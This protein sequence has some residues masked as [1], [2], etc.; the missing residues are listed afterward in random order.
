MATEEEEKKMTEAFEQELFQHIAESR[1]TR[2]EQQQ[3]PMRFPM[4]DRSLPLSAS[5]K[6]QLQQR[7]LRNSA[8]LRLVREMYCTAQR[9]KE[10]GMLATKALE[11]PSITV[12]SHSGSDLSLPISRLSTLQLLPRLSSEDS[13]PSSPATHSPTATA[14][15]GVT[16]AAARA[17]VPTISIAG[18]TRRKP[19][20]T[21]ARKP[22]QVHDVE[23]V[24]EE[25]E[26]E[27]EEE[28]ARNS[29][30]TDDELTFHLS[31]AWEPL[32][33]Q[34][35]MQSQLHAQLHSQMQPQ[36]LS[37]HYHRSQHPAM[38]GGR[39]TRNEE[40][41]TH[42]AASHATPPPP[43][44]AA[45]LAAEYVTWEPICRT[46]LDQLA[47]KVRGARNSWENIG[48]V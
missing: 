14:T 22:Q 9:N 24:D 25:K 35:Q 47:E 23:E 26:E 48:N 11:P 18:P 4:L 38:M 30:S 5:Q 44:H 34:S 39:N 33:S 41:S 15:R 2:L 3:H 40:P 42:A 19:R 45:P 1:A 10:T 21:R 12:I 36:F 7:Q 46:A 17:V 16:E 13:P 8:H 32:L 6:A 20:P 31:S 28:E 27:E 43:P 29:K 37:Q